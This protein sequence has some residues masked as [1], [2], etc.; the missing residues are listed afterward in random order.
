MLDLDL[1]FHSGSQH[2]ELQPFCIAHVVQ[3][4]LGDIAFGTLLVSD[5]WMGFGW[6]GLSLRLCCRMPGYVPQTAARS[7]PGSRCTFAAECWEHVRCLCLELSLRGARPIR[8]SACG[9]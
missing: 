3:H 1:S 6:P 9:D 4:S 5:L 8:G 7:L 2:V